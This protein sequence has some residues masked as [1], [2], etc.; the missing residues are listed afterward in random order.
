M[1]NTSVYLASC[2]FYTTNMD[3]TTSKC[4]QGAC[5]NV[6][7]PGKCACEYHWQLDAANRHKPHTQN[8]ENSD[9]ILNTPVLDPAPRDQPHLPPLRSNSTNAL[10]E[11]ATKKPITEQHISSSSDEHNE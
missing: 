3:K 10:D 4:Y 8:H 11:S 1:N 2:F 5:K 7:E 6:L 9:P